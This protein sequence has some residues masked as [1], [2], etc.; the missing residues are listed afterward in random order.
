M[1]TMPHAR[2]RKLI[3]CADL[4]AFFGQI[5][6]ISG[7]DPLILYSDWRGYSALACRARAQAASR[8]LLRSLRFFL[9]GRKLVGIDAESFVAMRD[10]RE[11]KARQ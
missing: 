7:L 1:G 10:S 6:P 4:S 11:P 2:R 5:G 9:T 8:M 3:L